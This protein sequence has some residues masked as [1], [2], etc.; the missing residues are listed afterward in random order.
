MK[1]KEFIGKY[2]IEGVIEADSLCL[3]S[4]DKENVII[5]KYLL[6]TVLDESKV[7]ALMKLKLKNSFAPLD[8]IKEFI[9]IYIVYENCQYTTLED[10]IETTEVVKYE[11][12]HELSKWI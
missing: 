10:Y 8:I 11:D 2:E 3:G 6:G 1:T 7:S 12:I 4:K 9:Y 5:K